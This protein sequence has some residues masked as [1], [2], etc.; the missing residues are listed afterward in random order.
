MMIPMYCCVG[1]FEN[2][3]D[4]FR[5]FSVFMRLQILKNIDKII[6]FALIIIG[7]IL[8]IVLFISIIDTNDNPGVIIYNNSESTNSE[9]TSSPENPVYTQ[10][11]ENST[12]DITTTSSIS[13]PVDI[14]KATF[15]DLTG[16]KGI[17]VKT[18]E[19]I[20]A[21]RSEHKIIRS[22]EELADIDGIGEKTVELLKNYFY[23]SPDATTTN[24]VTQKPVTDRTAITT[25]PKTLETKPKQTT[26][27]PKTTV[28]TTTIPKTSPETT[29]S[30]P[31]ERKPVN[32]NKA[33]A[34][35]FSENL[36]IDISDAEA[37]VELR[38]NIG[39]FTNIREL[40]FAITDELYLEIR[41]Y[42]YVE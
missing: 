12:E 19:K 11:D 13:Y 2:L 14:N 4:K 40:T 17:G 38:N 36:L 6:A 16:V 37:I 24:S 20:L 9:S 32:I 10:L 35:E 18:A 23:L 8:V 28:Y 33:S 21:Y 39:Y 25:S 5:H 34:Q 1:F 26:T 15:E 41:D 31:A 27:V 7:T 3:F 42:C 29:T 30:S 22:F